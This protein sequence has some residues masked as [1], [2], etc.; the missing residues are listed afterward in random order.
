MSKTF[1]VLITAK[2]GKTLL[3]IIDRLK[4]RTISGPRRHEDDACTICVF[5]HEDQEDILRKEDISLEIVDRD[6]EGTQKARRQEVGTGNRF[7]KGD[8]IPR[9]LGMK[10]KEDEHGLS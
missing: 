8:V 2:D 9:G 10:L 5:I 4:L 1:Q 7:L 6:V 3:E